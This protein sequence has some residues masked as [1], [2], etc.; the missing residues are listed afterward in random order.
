MSD[1]E[2]FGPL[3]LGT[4]P[5]EAL[6]DT[7]EQW[8][9]TYLAFV[10]RKINRPDFTLPLPRSYAVSSDFDHFPEEALPAILIMCE[11][12]RDPKKD[13]RGQY[14]ATFPL[15]V[16]LFV[17]GRDR[18]SSEQLAKFYAGAI[19]GLVTAKG[20]LGNFATATTWTDEKYHVADRNQRTIGRAEVC[21]NTEVRGVV[22]RLSGP[23]API[24]AP[25]P[26]TELPSLPRVK[27]GSVGLAPQSP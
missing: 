9:E 25:Q 15:K 8:M 5:E 20:S 11:G 7:L 24:P 12:I 10:V 14:R 4:E 13:G 16:G 18:K 17:E 22:R 2:T 23:A 3:V 1:L 19:R 6:Q 26:G 21:F 27:G